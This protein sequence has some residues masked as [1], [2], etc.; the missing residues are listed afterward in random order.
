MKTN[1]APNKLKLPKP[2]TFRHFLL[3]LIPAI[4]AI[5]EIQFSVQSWN[6][7]YSTLLRG[8]LEFTT[9]YLHTA[10]EFVGDLAI[11]AMI[12]FIWIYYKEYRFTLA[13]YLLALLIA[14]TV[15]S[16]L[17]I[18]SG[19]ARPP[20][21]VR[22][23]GD[24]L[25]EV[26]KYLETHDNPILKPEPG[27]YWMWFSKDR[28]GIDF[29]DRV[30]KEEDERSDLTVGDF[31]SFPS[32]HSCSAFLLAAY[33]TLLFPKA[34]ILWYVLAAMTALARVRLKRHYPGDILFGGAIGY[35][36]FHILFSQQWMFKVG[37]W[38]EE[39]VCK[40]TGEKPS[41]KLLG[42]EVIEVKNPEK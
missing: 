11:A 30:T 12:I 2:F 36:S 23:E 29:I 9:G 27:D 33:L 34:K 10:N 38:V 28:P 22:L 6:F 32:G 13:P 31:S 41:R 42:Q 8:P 24:K 7:I 37:Y 40:L 15:V 26:V 3:F 19:R 4:I 17:K 18:T 21:G 20:H 35:I 39:K 1:Q 14:S 5:I 25:E 16:T